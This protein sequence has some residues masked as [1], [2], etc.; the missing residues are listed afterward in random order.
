MVKLKI[1][2]KSKKKLI[3]KSYLNIVEIIILILKN[4]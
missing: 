2:V 3:K 1:T 4:S